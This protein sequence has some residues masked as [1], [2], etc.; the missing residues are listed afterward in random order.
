[1]V[2]YLL[3]KRIISTELKYQ[4][5]PLP[6]RTVRVQGILIIYL[7]VSVVDLIYFPW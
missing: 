1:M 2:P 3:F 5:V 7:Y 6:Y 4:L